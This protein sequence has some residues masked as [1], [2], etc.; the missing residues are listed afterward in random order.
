MNTKTSG[1]ALLSGLLLAAPTF[2]QLSE[3]AP[4]EISAQKNL[5]NLFISQTTFTAT[6]GNGFSRK[7]L[8]AV[9]LSK[10]TGPGPGRLVR[11]EPRLQPDSITIEVLDDKTKQVL[12]V[13]FRMFGTLSAQTALFKEA[14]TDG[15][16]TAQ[17]EL[18]I[19]GNTLTLEDNYNA[20]MTLNIPDFGTVVIPA[21]VTFKK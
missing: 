9:R 18:S 19:L 14:S 4:G 16:V 17:K 7:V 8:L 10:N 11:C 6:A 12:A 2:A 20:P 21:T 15:C 3:K 1:I 5:G 13:A